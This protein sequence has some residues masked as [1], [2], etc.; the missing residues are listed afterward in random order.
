MESLNYHLGLVEAVSFEPNRI[1]CGDCAEVLSRF[2][3]GC[4]DLIYADPPFFSNQQYEV[5]WG[6]GY[7]M[8]AFEDRWKGGI[9]NY[10]AWMEPKIRQC[11]KVL[12]DTGAM[13]LHCDWHAGAYLRVL[14]DKIFG[15]N[16]LVNEIIWKRTSAHTGEGKIKRF[17]TVHDTILFYSKSDS[18]SFTPQY[19]PLNEDYV[20]KFYRYTDEHGRRYRHDNLTASGVRHGDS[21]KPWHGI[22]PSK[23]GIHW[24]FTVQ[25]LDELEKE[26]R[27]YIPAKRGGV[28]A[29]KRYLDDSKGQLLQDIWDDIPPIQAQSAERLGYPTQKPEALLERIV[30]ASSNPTDLVLDPFCG[31]GTAIAVAHKLGRRWVGIDISPTACKLMAKRLRSL[32]AKVG[33]PIGLPR[34]VEQLRALEPFEFQN[35]VFEKLHG[36]VNPRKTG[37]FGIDGWVEL[38]VP[39]QV[40]QS[41]D[42]GR[43]VV[44]NFETAIQRQDKDRGV[45]VA[46]S[47]GSG[48]YEEV[49]RAKNNMNLDI[50]LKTVEEILKE[51]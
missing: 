18:N 19:V 49:A 41:D 9:Q 13:Y 36:R 34:S 27:I 7:E 44:D 46:F 10:I 16:R 21:G 40:K 28:P 24:K 25:R 20:S 4:I 1:Y 38:D 50:K 33:E 35:W 48:A 3:E 51:T 31:C 17:G 45:I 2:P 5:L 30:G 14:M 11:H 22:D 39:C 43:N 26:G 6:D 37:D 23:K 12:K 15:E 32:R 29:Y 47:F 42:I 8:R